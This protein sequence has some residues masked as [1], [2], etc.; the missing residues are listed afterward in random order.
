ML[1]ILI[2][3]TLATTCGSVLA[4]PLYKCSVDGTVTYSSEKCKGKT[5]GEISPPEPRKLKPGL[6]AA[7]LER[8]RALANRMEKDRLARD[9]RDEKSASSAAAPTD[10]AEPIEVLSAAQRRCARLRLDKKLADQKLADAKEADRDALRQ[11]A[12]SK[13]DMLSSECPG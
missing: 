6:A 10:N 7:D 1:R 8:D 12:Q 3:A 9:A 5:L 11:D 13:G 2:A 4:Q